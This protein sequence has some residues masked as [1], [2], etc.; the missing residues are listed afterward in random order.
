M[1]RHLGLPVCDP[2]SADFVGIAA[3]LQG[4]VAG[5]AQRRGPDTG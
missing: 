5:E 3:Q 1:S 2:S 4:F